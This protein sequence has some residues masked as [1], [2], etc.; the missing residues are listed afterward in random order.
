MV[1][2]EHSSVQVSGIPNGPAVPILKFEHVTVRFEG[3]PALD[4]V[5]FELYVGDTRVVLGA[6]AS[7][8]TVLLKTAIGLIRPESGRVSLFGQ[9][10]SLLD[11]E[12]LLA[13]RR[14]VGFLFQD[15]GLFDSLTVEQNVGYPLRNDFV[16]KLP[17]GEVRARVKEALEFVGLGQ[18]EDKYPSELSG[19]MQRRL[20]IARVI[21]TKAPLML[22]DSPIAG[23]D[24]ITAH[25]ILSLLIR[26]RDTLDTTSVVVT[27]KKGDLLANYSYD[28]RSGKLVHQ[29]SRH[30]RT[31]FLVLREG[32]I[33]FSGSEAALHSS[34][35]P[36]VV[37]F[38]RTN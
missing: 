9:D 33:V 1:L 21:V 38:A 30:Q 8:K 31:T 11:E 32:K 13:L 2:G 24:P 34:R 35:D 10:I 15:G 37:E 27:Y 20:G 16:A 18:T 4:D 28:R 17:Q 3:A 7:G 12:K 23:L 36:Y 14:R 6:A 5:S 26:Q 29:V 22:Y 19:G 25:D